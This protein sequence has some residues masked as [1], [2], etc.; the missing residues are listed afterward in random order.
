[1]FFYLLFLDC[2]LYN[3][4]SMN[5]LQHLIYGVMFCYDEKQGSFEM[6]HRDY[7]ELYSPSLMELVP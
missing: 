6:P 4:H 1:M 5:E 3:V 2:T 7:R